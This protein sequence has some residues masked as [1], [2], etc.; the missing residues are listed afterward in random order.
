M[1]AYRITGRGPGGAAAAAAAAATSGKTNRNGKP[2]MEICVEP[3]IFSLTKVLSLPVL[4]QVTGVC[5]VSLLDL[6]RR[7][8]VTAFENSE[9]QLR[10]PD[11]RGSNRTR[12]QEAGGVDTSLVSGLEH[13]PRLVGVPTRDCRIEEF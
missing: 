1:F 4:S 6:S 11:Q 13:S 7:V 3:F 10:I 5:K 8:T 2:D 12:P 9:I